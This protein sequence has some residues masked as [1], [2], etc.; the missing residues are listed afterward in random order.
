MSY[1]LIKQRVEVTCINL[2]A[3]NFAVIVYQQADVTS[4]KAR[5]TE[6]PPEAP[7]TRQS[8]VGPFVFTATMSD[9]EDEETSGSTSAVV[10]LGPYAHSCGYCGSDGERSAAKSAVNAA[11][12]DALRLACAVYQKMIDRGWRRSGTYCYKPDL[13]AS[14][15]PQYT[16]KFV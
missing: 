14:C 8:R 16:I 12:L 4:R 5:C 2:E 7:V 1:S 15:C 9:S 13:R 3:S 6:K 10:P 11:T